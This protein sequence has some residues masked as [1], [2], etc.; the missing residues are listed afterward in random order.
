MIRPVNILYHC[1]DLERCKKF[2]SDKNYMIN[3]EEDGNWLG[4]G[5]YFWDNP[6]NYKYWLKVKQ[7]KK[8]NKNMV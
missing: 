7:R 6:S 2:V 5:M 3:S 4:R 1:N 8:I